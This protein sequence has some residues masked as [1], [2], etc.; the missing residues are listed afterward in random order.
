[1]RGDLA[2]LSMI[3][4][5]RLRVDVERGLV[6]A[7]KSNTPD[8]AVGS[9]TSKGYLRVCVTCGGAQVHFMAHRI[10]WVS[11]NGPVQTGEQ[12]DH[13]N[14][15]KTDNRL[16]NLEAVAGRENMRRAARD[17]LTKG[18]WREALRDPQTGQFLTKRAAGRLLDGVEHNA[19]PVIG[20]A[21]G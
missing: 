17:G 1:M 19:F 2:I 6:F 15:N 21:H 20:G 14:G 8:K 12:I 4:T 3:E 11:V 10:V 13:L 5:G 18:G 16:C 7:A 9:L